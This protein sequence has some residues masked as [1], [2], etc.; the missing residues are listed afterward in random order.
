MQP[1]GMLAGSEVVPAI[2]IRD[3]G[4]LNGGA[5]MNTERHVQSQ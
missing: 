3:G 2:Q 5:G 4:P 1:A